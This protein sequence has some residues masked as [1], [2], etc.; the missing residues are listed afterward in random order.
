MI[1]VQVLNLISQHKID[2]VVH[3]AAY[4]A[5]G[6]SV[7][8]P[9]QYYQNNVTGMCILLEVMSAN[10]VFNLVYSSS[11]TVYGTPKSLPSTETSITGNCTNPYGRTKYFTEEILKDVCISDKKWNVISL[12]YFNP[13][14]AHKSG[15]IGEFPKGEPK[16][17]LP[18]ITRVALG[19]LE[20]LK[21]F[22]NDYPTR[23]GTGV[24]DYSHVVD[25]AE[26][27]VAALKKLSEG[28]LLNFQVFNLAVGKG[29]SVLEVVKTFEKVSG[30]KVAY[31]FVARRPGDI[32]ENFAS[33]ALAE[34]VLDWKAKRGLEEMCEDAWR[35]QMKN[36]NGFA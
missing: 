3:F 32:A 8:V 14:G 24:R 29:Y 34:K 26:G 31:E 11:S 1:S 19:K 35:W 5:V 12:R 36:P 17:L 15:L 28:K 18:Y 30:H 20:K 4:K 7:R 33:A 27:H 22:G 25:I 9:L 10:G 21:I 16:N 13:I 2:C 6:E 23:D